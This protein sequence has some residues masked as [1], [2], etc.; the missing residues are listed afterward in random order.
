MGVERADVTHWLSAYVEAWK[1]YDPGAIRELFSK[2]VE[3]RYHPD[4]EPIRGREAVVEAWL[5][6]GDHEG[7]SSRDRHGT[8]DAGY[9]VV[10]VEG[11]VAVATGAS[12]YLSEPGGTVDEIYDNCF[13]I[14]FDDEGRCAEFT[15]WFMKRPARADA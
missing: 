3:Y 13:V 15:E 4:D 5:G 6:E 12:T 14:R 1:S 10:A 9:R 8:Y 11:D 2:D 7:A